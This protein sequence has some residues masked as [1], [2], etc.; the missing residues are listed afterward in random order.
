[1]CVH[2]C[3]YGFLCLWG[4]GCILVHVCVYVCMSLYMSL[5]VSVYV[6]IDTSMCV[7]CV[8]VYLSLCVCISMSTY[9]SESLSLSLWAHAYVCLFVL[10][11][12]TSALSLHTRITGSCQHSTLCALPVPMGLKHHF[13]QEAS[14]MLRECQ[15]F[16]N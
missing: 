2:A 10:P 12:L 16:R 5:Y 6:F 15:H 7:M 4:S 9:V 8:S 1:V 13:G 14:T 11:E 3:M